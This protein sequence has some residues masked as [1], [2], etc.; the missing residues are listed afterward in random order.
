MRCKHGYCCYGDFI[1]KRHMLPDGTVWEEDP[2]VVTYGPGNNWYLGTDKIVGPISKE[3]A[4]ELV[5]EW[6]RRDRQT[7]GSASNGKS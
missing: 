6:Y 7:K 1:P 3:K 4:E 5:L 2:R